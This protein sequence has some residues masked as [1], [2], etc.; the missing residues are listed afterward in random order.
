MQ[1]RHAEALRE[2]E[3]ALELQPSDYSARQSLAWTLLQLDRPDDAIREMQKLVELKP[4][5]RAYRI[6]LAQALRSAMSLVTDPRSR[7]GNDTS[8]PA[9]TLLEVAIADAQQSDPSA[10][11]PHFGDLQ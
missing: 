3:V 1:E 8:A 6:S 10:T 4:T 2:L 7:S 11:Q 9:K 5:K